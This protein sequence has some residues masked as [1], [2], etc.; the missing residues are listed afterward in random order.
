MFLGL[1]K[2][3]ASLEQDPSAMPAMMEDVDGRQEAGAIPE[4]FQACVES[5]ETYIAVRRDDL[6]YMAP[7]STSNE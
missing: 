6:T 1:H 3:Y 4:D 5:M 2:S 7:E